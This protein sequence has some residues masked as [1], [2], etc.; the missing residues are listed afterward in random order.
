M[1]EN[2]KDLKALL[3]LCRQNGVTE[4]DWGKGSLKLGEMPSQSAN[5]DIEELD[6]QEALF[7][8]AAE[9]PLTHEE[10]V[11]FAAGA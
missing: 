8:E 7:I 2:L 3:K 4:I 11:A 9:A 6:D 5:P 1:I 10:A